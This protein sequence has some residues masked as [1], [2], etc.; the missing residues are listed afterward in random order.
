MCYHLQDRMC[1][2]LAI[3]RETHWKSAVISSLPCRSATAMLKVRILRKGAQT[4]CSRATPTSAWMKYGRS[5]HYT[6]SESQQ[7]RASVQIQAAALVRLAHRH[8][9]LLKPLAKRPSE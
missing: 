4:E 7:A 3:Y 8:D 5:S 9:M 6:R 1:Y 2:H